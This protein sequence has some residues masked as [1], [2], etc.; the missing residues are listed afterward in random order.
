MRSGPW[1]GCVR[2]APDKRVLPKPRKQN[3]ALGRLVTCFSGDRQAPAP[4]SSQQCH[5]WESPAPCPDKR[6]PSCLRHEP[7]LQQRELAEPPATWHLRQYSFPGGWIL[8]LQQAPLS[9]IC[10]FGVLS[11]GVQGTKMCAGSLKSRGF[12]MK[13]AEDNRKAVAKARRGAAPGLKVWNGSAMGA[14]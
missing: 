5:S 14:V 7:G 9:V 2:K 13:R 12:I 11:T 1:R 4:G 10:P 8:V 6:Q 3:L